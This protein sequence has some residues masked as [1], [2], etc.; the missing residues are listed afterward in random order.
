MIDDK[1]K[2]ERLIDGDERVSFL[3]SEINKTPSGNKN[4]ILKV[5]IFWRVHTRRAVFFFRKT[6]LYIQGSSQELKDDLWYSPVGVRFWD[7]FPVQHS[8]WS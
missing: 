5:L 1:I 4:I 2:S 3:K 6:A 7:P 8:R